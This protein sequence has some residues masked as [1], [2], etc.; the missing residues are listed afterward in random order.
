MSRD[1]RIYLD[2]ILRA[3]EK[4]H[5]FTAGMTPLPPADRGGTVTCQCLSA[6]ITRPIP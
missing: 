2:D 1:W 6:R 3:C 5:R 4:V